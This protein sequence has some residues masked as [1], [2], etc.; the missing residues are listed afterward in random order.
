MSNSFS[1]LW[2]TSAPLP[3]KP[4]P[5][6]LTLAA[7]LAEESDKRHRAATT[8]DLQPHKAPDVS[9]SAWAGLDSL[10]SGIKAKVNDDDDWGLRDFGSAAAAVNSDSNPKS[11]S[12]S[13]TLWDIDD[14]AYSTGPTSHPKSTSTPKTLWDLDDFASSTGPTPH[15]ESRSTSK[16]LWD[17]DN[18]A[19]STIPTPPR[20][21]PLHFLD[22]DN[23]HDNLMG[24]IGNHEDEEDILGVLSKPVEV[25]IAKKVFLFLLP[26]HLFFHFSDEIDLKFINLPL[27]SELRFKNLDGPLT[28]YISWTRFKTSFSTSPHPRPNC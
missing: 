24:G 10:D 28:S 13:K 14:F 22:D 5:Q 4:K 1:D 9:H 21:T 6:T 16:T 15:P 11:T 20:S 2:N 8:V 18:F 17:L 19:S 3:A 27:S 23:D 26:H 7:R 12:K 25:L